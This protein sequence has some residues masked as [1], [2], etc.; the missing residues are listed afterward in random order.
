VPIITNG[1]S[2]CSS[3]YAASLMQSDSFHRER[4]FDRPVDFLFMG[5]VDRAGDQDRTGV[6]RRLVDFALEHDLNVKFMLEYEDFTLEEERKLINQA[7][8]GLVCFKLCM[9]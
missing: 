8:V 9:E 2:V 4:D 7:K 6:Y 1:H 5:L 3:W